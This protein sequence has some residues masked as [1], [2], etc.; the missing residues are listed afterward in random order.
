MRRG[1]PLIIPSCP[2]NRLRT[3]IPL[4]VM[5]NWRMSL[6]WSLPRIL[7]TSRALWT[8]ALYLHVAQEDVGVNNKRDANIMLSVFPQE[9][10]ALPGQYGRQ[11]FPLQRVHKRIGQVAQLERVMGEALEVGEAIHQY[12]TGAS[13]AGQ[14]LHLAPTLWRSCRETSGLLMMMRSFPSSSSRR[15]SQPKLAASR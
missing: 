8:A 5:S 1:L 6:S 9:D 11:P 10:G 2:S 15:K 7:S 3:S 13:V 4:G 14:D 12:P